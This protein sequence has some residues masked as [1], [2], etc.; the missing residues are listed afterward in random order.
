MTKPGTLTLPAKKLFEIVS[1]LPDGDIHIEE[2][3][4]GKSVTIAAERFESKMQTLPPGEFPTPPQD[5]G[6]SCTMT[7]P[8]PSRLPTCRW[9]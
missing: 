1:A 4:N 2:D 9:A 3:K 7:R 6:P 5:A 8:T